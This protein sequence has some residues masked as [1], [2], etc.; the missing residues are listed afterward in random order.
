MAPP[1]KPTRILELTGRLK[2]DPKRFANRQNEPRENRPIG[3]PPLRL[4]LNQQGIW[5]EIL[6]QLVAGVVLQS[7]HEAFEHLVGL[8]AKRRRN[9]LSNPEL[10]ALLRLYERFGMT[11]ADR[12][13]VSV[14]KDSDAKNRFG[15]LG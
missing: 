6:G 8:V 12:S 2:H 13:R 1:R 9:D 15:T 3:G 4:N 10:M 14:R 11:P 5:R 7:D